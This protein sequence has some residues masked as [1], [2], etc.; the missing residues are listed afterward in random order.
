MINLLNIIIFIKLLEQLFDISYRELQRLASLMMSHQAA[1][2]TLQP[3]ALVNEAT[4]RLLGAESLGNIANSQHF[5]AS[6]AQAMRCVLVDH[7]RRRTTKRRGHGLERHDL[8]VVLDDFEAFNHVDFLDL[9][10]ALEKLE[11][12]S[13][14]YFSLVQFR[15]FLGMSVNEIAK[16]RNV[17]KTTIERDWRFVRAWLAEELMG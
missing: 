11:K 14:R 8:D 13:E 9:N 7:A 2:H 1:G 15:F 3:T 4:L 17:S 12:L 5:Y 16:H 6:L 10:E